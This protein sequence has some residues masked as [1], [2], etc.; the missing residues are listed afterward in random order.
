[1]SER[2]VS[3]SMMCP[4]R[5]HTAT[6]VI[7]AVMPEM[8]R[9]TTIAAMVKRLKILHG[10]ITIHVM[11]LT[12]MRIVWF[13]NHWLAPCWQRVLMTPFDYLPMFVPFGSARARLGFGLQINF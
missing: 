11:N 2:M 1:M 9:E 4:L 12:T 7:P 6:I 10:L 13:A 5:I 8:Q 3:R